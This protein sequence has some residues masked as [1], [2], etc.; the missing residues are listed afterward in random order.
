MEMT[1]FQL[2]AEEFQA[3]LQKALGSI[4]LLN[5]EKRTLLERIASLE[6]E[7]LSLETEKREWRANFYRLQDHVE[8]GESGH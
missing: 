3:K 8:S 6:K 5:Q 4:A 2:L 1:R 7:N